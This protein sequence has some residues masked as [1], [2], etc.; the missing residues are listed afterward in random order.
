MRKNMAESPLIEPKPEQ[1]KTESSNVAQHVG[2][3]SDRAIQRVV[4]GNAFLRG[5]LYAR[6]NAVADLVADDRTAH[7]KIL[8]RSQEEPYQ[9]KVNVGDAGEVTSQCSC[10]GWRGPTG[11]CK[12]VAALL[13]AL[14]DRER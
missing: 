10:P 8:V 12:H 1:S 4:G 5:R 14:R 6:R 3:L 7:A 11:H 13:V 9:V 2:R